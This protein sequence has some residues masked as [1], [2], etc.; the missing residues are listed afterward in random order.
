MHPKYNSQHCQQLAAEAL[1]TVLQE[2]LVAI[3]LTTTLQAVNRNDMNNINYSKNIKVLHS[4]TICSSIQI[5]LL[6]TNPRISQ[7]LKKFNQIINNLHLVAEIPP[8]INPNKLHN[9]MK[10]NQVQDLKIKI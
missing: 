10:E 1:L 8:K 9:N 4:S 5:H 7:L 6:Y 3:I 2:H